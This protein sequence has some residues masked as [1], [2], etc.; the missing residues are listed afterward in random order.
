MQGCVEL[1]GC[2]SLFEFSIYF[3]FFLFFGCIFLEGPWNTLHCIHLPA[4]VA[5]RM[6]KHKQRVHF[7]F[8]KIIFHKNVIGELRKPVRKTDFFLILMFFSLKSENL[9][10]AADGS[11][12]VQC[13]AGILTCHPRPHHNDLIVADWV[14]SLYVVVC[15]FLYACPIKYKEK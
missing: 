9:K 7:I 2:F 6:A 12:S 11:R 5:N 14:P 8:L 13:V 10:M 15:V 4:H 1:L 3:L